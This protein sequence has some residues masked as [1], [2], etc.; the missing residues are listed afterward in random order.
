MSV[1]VL[2]RLFFTT[3]SG[4]SEMIEGFSNMDTKEYHKVCAV[5]K[6]GKT[7]QT[8]KPELG[9]GFDGGRINRR[10]RH[11]ATDGVPL[12]DAVDMSA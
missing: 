11:A 6:G 9:Q 1:P 10:K 12:L 8:S 7:G 4:F 5:L 2:V 3:V